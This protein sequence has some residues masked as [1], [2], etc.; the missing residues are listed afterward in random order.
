ML[1][2][3]EVSEAAELV[4]VDLENAIVGIGDD[5]DILEL[6]LQDKGLRDE[7]VLARRG[8][9]EDVELLG[10]AVEFVLF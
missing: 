9:E 7:G 5:R 1:I 6:R 10:D 4:H 2:V 3:E 8:C